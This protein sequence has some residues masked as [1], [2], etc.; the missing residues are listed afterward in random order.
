MKRAALIPVLVL[1]TAATAFGYG[2]EGHEAI[3]EL[4]RQML[5]SEARAAVIQILGNDNL[6]ATSTWADELKLAEHGQ[7]PLANNPEAVAINAKF[8]ANHLWHFADLPPGHPP[9]TETPV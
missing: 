6:A 1:A 2:R 7:G 8:P 9:F 3:G 5:R 4:A